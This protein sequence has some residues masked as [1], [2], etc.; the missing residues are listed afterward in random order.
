MPKLQGYDDDQLDDLDE[1]I[2]DAISDDEGRLSAITL[3]YHL[4][5]RGWILIHPKEG[6]E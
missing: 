4:H 6:G 1:L 5:K 2:Q 3:V